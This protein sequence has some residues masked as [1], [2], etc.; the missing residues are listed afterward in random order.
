ML[1]KKLIYRQSVLCAVAIGLSA[2][3]AYASDEC[4]LNGGT[5]GGASIFGTGSLACGPNASGSTGS[6]QTVVGG[7][8][9]VSR[10]ATTALGYGA[11]ATQAGAI[12]IGGFD[13]VL[14]SQR[15][16]ADG[17][18]SVAIGH[19]TVASAA[20]SVAL[21]AG[22][23]ADQA[24]TVSVGTA[25]NQR[26]IVNVAAGVNATDAVNVGQLNSAVAGVTTDVTTLQT[27]VTVLQTDVNTIESDVTTL[28]TN[29]TANTADIGALETGLAS[30]TA[31]RIAADMALDTRVD[32]LETI[33]ANLD[34]RFDDVADRSDA[35]TAAAVA[36]S[37]AMFLPGKTFNLTG[38]VGAYRGAVA[39][40]IQLGALVSDRVAVNAG[41][42]HGFNK[43]G[44]TAVR[45]GFTLG[46]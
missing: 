24:N 18:D 11:F 15:T 33:T 13:P 3:P 22:S 38:N 31:S 7:D 43:G 32:A 21:G 17:V 37:G 2:M 46:W 23:V 29:V 16:R 4:L 14:S 35:G 28:E 30:E 42:A 8:A 39:G 9:V 20:G 19:Q 26:M 36:L 34:E 44:K 40:A 45:A 27:D 41:V 10:N 1:S 25:D 6:Y 12:A 5:T